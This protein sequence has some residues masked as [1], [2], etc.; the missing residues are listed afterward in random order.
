MRFRYTKKEIDGWPDTRFLIAL[1]DERLS[2]LNPYSNLAR[3]LQQIRAKLQVEHK[4][5]DFLVGRRKGPQGDVP[6]K[7][8]R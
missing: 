3:R 2:D 1:V 4:L 7:E 6:I 8:S 5:V